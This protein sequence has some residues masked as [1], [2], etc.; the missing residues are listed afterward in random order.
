[1]KPTKAK[2]PPLGSQADKLIN[3]LLEFKTPGFHKCVET[4]YSERGDRETPRFCILHYTVPVFKDGVL[5]D[6]EDHTYAGNRRSIASILRGMMKKGFEPTFEAGTDEKARA[7]LP[8]IITSL[9][10]APTLTGWFPVVR[11]SGAF[12]TVGFFPRPELR[13]ASTWV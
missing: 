8:G 10:N 4:L 6:Y 11:M 13:P 12:S 5:V 2:T 7:R 3:L 9:V 1:M